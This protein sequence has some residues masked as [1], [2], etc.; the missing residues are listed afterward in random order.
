[1]SERGAIPFL[2]ATASR[3]DKTQF[4]KTNKEPNWTFYNP[5]IDGVKKVDKEHDNHQFNNSDFVFTVIQK[6]LIK[7]KLIEVIPALAAAG[8]SAGAVVGGPIGAAIGGV[9][10][11]AVGSIFYFFT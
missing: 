8:A 11:A 1:M 3:I 2:M 4:N 10:G 5:F 9:V 7:K 6:E